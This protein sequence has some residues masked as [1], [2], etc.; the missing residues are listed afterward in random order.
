VRIILDP[1]R[2]EIRLT[3]W[4]KALGLMG[5][6]SVRRADISDVEVLDDGVRAAMRS[7]LKAGLRLPWLRYVARTISLEEAFLV[8]RRVPTLAF[9]IADQGRLRRVLVST[10]QAREI[11][12]ALAR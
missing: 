3:A 6:I 1:E 2:L 5:D 10:P 11:A 4:E 8:R 12:A 9:S 7:G